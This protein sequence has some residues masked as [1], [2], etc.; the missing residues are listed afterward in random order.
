MSHF[1]VIVCLTQAD[2]DKHGDIEDV[3]AEALIPFKEVGWGANDPEGLYENYCEWHDSVPEYRQEYEEQSVQSFRYLLGSCDFFTRVVEKLGDKIPA[4]EILEHRAAIDEADTL[5]KEELG[6]GT[7]NPSQVVRDKAVDAFVEKHGA[8]LEGLFTKDL[9]GSMEEWVEFYHGYKPL[10][11]KPSRYGY[12]S[13]PRSYWDWY[14]IGGRWRGMFKIRGES[15]R[16]ENGIGEPGVGELIAME[17]GESLKTYSTRDVDIVR[18][19]QL[20]WE[21]MEAKAEEQALLHYRVYRAFWNQGCP[22]N[23]RFQDPEDE[24][25]SEWMNFSVETLAEHVGLCDRERSGEVT[26]DSPYW[27]HV[28]DYIAA[29][30]LQTAMLK[31]ADAVEKQAAEAKTAGR[32]NFLF[33]SEFVH[34]PEDLIIGGVDEIIR[35]FF[36]EAT[37]YVQIF[38]KCPGTAEQWWTE[39]K[40]NYPLISSYALLTT[41]GEWKAPGEMGWWGCSSDTLEDRIKH[42]REKEQFFRDLPDETWLVNVDCHI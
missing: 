7:A 28:Q 24:D 35:F 3:V 36:R 13:N 15:L 34:T 22:H 33:S 38:K 25:K 42:A 14:S 9:F 18:K 40:W 20:D 31:H 16:L 4:S 17:K 23:F 32:P 37:P 5:S 12:Y 30:S 39:F 8:L 11:G 29:G 27:Q 1:T 41:D 10:E 21:A 6:W 26:E 2:V 19:D